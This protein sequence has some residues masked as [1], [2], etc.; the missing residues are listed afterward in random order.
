MK[1]SSLKNLADNS[2]QQQKLFEEKINKQEENNSENNNIKKIFN[3]NQ[4][5]SNPINNVVKTNYTEK[6]TIESF[7]NL[8]DNHQRKHAT[9]KLHSDFKQLDHRFSITEISTCLFQ[10]LLKRIYAS[11]MK[12]NLN[13]EKINTALHLHAEKGT[14]LHNLISGKVFELSKEL[15]KVVTYDEYIFDPETNIGGKPDLFFPNDEL[16]I[17]IKTS[18]PNND[19][20]YEYTIQ[21][22]L[23]IYLIR[24]ILKINVTEGHIWY[25]L[26]NNKIVTINYDENK[27]NNYLKVFQILRDIINEIINLDGKD[28]DKY[29]KDNKSKIEKLIDNTRCKYCLFEKYCNNI[30]TNKTT[31]IKN[32][33]NSFFKVTIK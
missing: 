27:M 32:D 7:L 25:P 29:L 8:Y 19:S 5:S 2:S 31:E 23:Q 3:N 26:S 13:L 10:T 18:Q 6:L 22:Y 33:E 30:F 28:V 4:E 24:K 20:L 12:I 16:L 1:I 21:V 15:R 11:K 17:E 9:S 14:F